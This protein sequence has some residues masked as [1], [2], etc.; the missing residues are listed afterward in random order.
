[1]SMPMLASHR[2][3]MLSSVHGDILEIGFGTGANLPYYPRHV[4]RLVAV[5]FNRG[6]SSIAQK[7]IKAF[8][9]K[10]EFHLMDALKL[11]FPDASFDSVVTSWTLCS[12][13]G[14]ERVLSEIHRVLKPEGVFCFLEHGLSPDKTVQRFQQI[15]NGLNEIVSCSLTRDIPALVRNAGFEIKPLETFYIEKFLST[16]GYMYQG[17]ARKNR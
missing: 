12:V 11:T 3:T 4:R 1:M 13:K 6:M 14:I 5:D 9:I 2:R 15:F 8:Q 16:H 17:I 10:V 7:R